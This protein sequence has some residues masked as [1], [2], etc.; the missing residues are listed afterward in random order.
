MESYL[1]QVKIIDLNTEFALPHQISGQFPQIK[2]LSRS[3][4][5]TETA[6]RAK[7]MH[8]LQKNWIRRCSPLC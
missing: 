2:N 4:S 1:S 3:L 5:K 6:I 8:I 7:N